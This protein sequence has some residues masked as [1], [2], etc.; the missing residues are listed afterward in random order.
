M[1]LLEH[2]PDFPP[3][4]AGAEVLAVNLPHWHPMAPEPAAEARSMLP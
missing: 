2:L 1:E 4:R 3:Q